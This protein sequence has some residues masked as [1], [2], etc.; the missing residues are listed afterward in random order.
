MTASILV[1]L[2]FLLI[3]C[4]AGFSME[5]LCQIEWKREHCREE[6]MKSVRAAEV[7]WPVRQ[8]KGLKQSTRKGWELKIAD[9]MHKKPLL[10]L[11]LQLLPQEELFRRF[12][13][14][15]YLAAAEQ[16]PYI[17]FR[18]IRNWTIHRMVCCRVPKDVHTS[19][20]FLTPTPCPCLTQAVRAGCRPRLTQGRLF[21]HHI[22][23]AGALTL[24]YMQKA[25]VQLAVAAR[26]P[27]HQASLA[28]HQ[29]RG[30][31]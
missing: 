7:Q 1:W 11:L 12:K 2:I 10:L 13:A 23:I 24:T 14:F 22:A 21:S 9:F 4:F 5:S 8:Q 20:C 26:W 16:E 18:T 19:N 15:N 28:V 27:G 6:T 30:I 3:V 31:S 29:G 25:F 17:I